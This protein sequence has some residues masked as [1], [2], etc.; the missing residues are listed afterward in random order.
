MAIQ[1]NKPL[2][3]GNGS[4][5]TGEK[6]S[7][8][9]LAQASQADA[10]EALI[11]AFITAGIVT[12]KHR[13]DALLDTPKMENRTMISFTTRRKEAADHVID[14]C[15]LLDNKKVMGA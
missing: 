6:D 8:T 11:D 9:A 5:T 3:G 4:M 2:T 1:I 10:I 13:D 14:V 15:N 7:G 12:G